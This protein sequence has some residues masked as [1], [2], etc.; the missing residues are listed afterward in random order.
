MKYYGTKNN[1]NYGFYSEPFEGAIELSE[2]TWKILQVEQSLGKKI[3]SDNKIVFSTNE[4]DKFY[5]NDDGK[6]TQRTNDEFNTLIEERNKEQEIKTIKK[7]I[8]DLDKKRIR[9]ICE[10]SIKDEITGETWLDFYNTQIIELRNKLTTLTGT[11][12]EE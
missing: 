4:P 7:Q 6:W 5:I 8:E 10:P 1:L 9:A 12:Y 3:I 2:E 11:T